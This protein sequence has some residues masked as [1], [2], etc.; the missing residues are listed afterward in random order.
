MKGT[1]YIIIQI[2]AIL[3]V[4]LSAFIISFNYV[5]KTRKL[6]RA[7]ELLRSQLEV[8]EKNFDNIYKE[9]HDNIGQV[10]SLTKLNLHSL[11]PDL[12]DTASEKINGS[13]ELLSKAITDLRNIGKSLNT[14]VLKEA[15]LSEVIRQELLIMARDGSCQTIFKQDGLPIRLEDQTEL[16]LFR[17]FQET[18]TNSIHL[19]AKTVNVRLEYKPQV[20]NLRV[21][22]DGRGFNTTKL[23][24]KE[25][26]LYYGIRDMQS[27]A[28]LIG[29][30]LKLSS[31]PGK[32]TSVMI[33]LPL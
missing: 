25:R 15:G 21:C 27:R 14:Q 26:H 2:I 19:K 13:K 6:R 7:N 33:N 11:G 10:L 3:A 9:I 20:I 18:L 8:Q 32:G 29:A 4:V 1:E 23:R 22:D 17:V 5:G 16:I 24:S 30:D 31:S 28:S 12:S